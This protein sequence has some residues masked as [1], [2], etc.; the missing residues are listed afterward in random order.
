MCIV[1]NVFRNDSLFNLKKITLFLSNLGL[2][3]TWIRF[4]S[5]LVVASERA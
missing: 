5:K 3:P 1:L 4:V 2:S